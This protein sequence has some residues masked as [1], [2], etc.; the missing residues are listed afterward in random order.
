MLAGIGRPVEGLG[1]LNSP[2]FHPQEQQHQ[3]PKMI[4]EVGPPVEVPAHAAFQGVAPEQ[5]R[6]WSAAS[7]SSSKRATG[8]AAIRG[9]GNRS[10]PFCAATWKPAAFAC[11]SS[12]STIFCA[13]SADFQIGRA[14]KRRTPRCGDPGTAAALQWRAPCSCGPLWP[15]YRREDSSVGR[16]AGRHPRSSP[17]RRKVPQHSGQRGG[18]RHVDQRGFFRR[19]RRFRS[20]RRARG[21]RA[22]G[23]PPESVS[24]CTRSRSFRRKRARRRQRPEGRPQQ[25]REAGAR[26]R[27]S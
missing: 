6:C 20:S 4:S 18:Q 3:T 16:S 25:R 8:R 22:S 11:I 23:S 9:P 7:V 21:R 26:A 5:T 10:P 15:G 24:A 17:C 14:A 19:R 27:R 2:S 1:R 13:L 12:R